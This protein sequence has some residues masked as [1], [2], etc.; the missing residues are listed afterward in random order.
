MHVHLVFVIKYR[1]NVFTKIILEELRNIFHNVCKDFGAK[2]AE[3]E[4]ERDPEHLLVNYS[5][6]VSVSKIVNS[7][8]GVSARLVQKNNCPTVQ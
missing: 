8:K 1:R 6:K 4:G 3:F 2:L 7:L 5:P